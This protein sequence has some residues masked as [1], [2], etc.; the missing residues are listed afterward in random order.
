VLSRLLTQLAAGT[1]ENIFATSGH[2]T[3]VLTL[4]KIFNDPARNYGKGLSW[5]G[6]TIHDCAALLLR[7]LKCLPEPVIPYRHYEQLTAPFRNFSNWL[8]L[9]DTDK[10]QESE[11]MD[12][13]VKHTQQQVRELPPLNRQLLLY[14]LD[15][16]AV[17]ASRAEL[18]KMP[19]ARLV[20]A[21]HPAVLSRRPQEMDEGEHR[22]AQDIVIFF[23]DQQD[24]FL[25]GLGP[26]I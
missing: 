13:L 15:K 18:N 4:E 9:S 26:P 5:A 11:P 12:S 19:S 22:L 14:L 1:E 21:F 25:I 7:Y 10:G 17:F 3:R 2:P 23:V 8:Q 6:F 24:N 16:L 20:S